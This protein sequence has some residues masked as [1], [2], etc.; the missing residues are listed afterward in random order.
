MNTAEVESTRIR[1][2]G[3]VAAA[4]PIVFVIGWAV[5]ATTQDGFRIIRDDESALAAIGADHPWITMTG[6]TALGIGILALSIALA[7]LL[8]G[9]RRTIGCLLLATAGVCAIIQALV[10]EDCV[11]DLGLCA[12]AGRSEATSWRQ[13]VHDGASGIAFI[14]ILAAAFI[15]A[16]P[17]RR[18]GWRTLAKY[19][20][21]TGAIGIVLLVFYI[22]VSESAIAGLAEFLFLLVTLGWVAVLGLRTAGRLHVDPVEAVAP[23]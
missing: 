13:S 23:I 16:G 1:L 14:A 3:L 18:L 4:G 2:L 7:A 9:R 21:A 17:L 8:N 22:L 11:S 19:S 5:G 10:R 20:I 12:A 6:D 15:L